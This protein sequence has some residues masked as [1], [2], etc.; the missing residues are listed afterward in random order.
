MKN[1]WILVMMFSSFLL[2]S[3][4]SEYDRIVKKELASDVIYEDLFLGMKLGQTQKEFF[5]ECWQLNSEGIV[6]Q[7]PDNENVRYSMPK[8]EIPN[9]SQNVDVLF[10]GIFDE[11]KVMRGMRMKFFYVGWAPWNDELKSDVLV[12]KLKGYFT[13]TYK[14]NDFIDLDLGVE[15]IKGYVKVDGNR[16]ILMY[17][18]DTK[19]VMVKIEDLRYKLNKNE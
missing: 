3:C 16:Q 19:E 2:I 8:G 5:A 4:K 12:E 17:P 11:S 13:K 9:E 15:A 18:V 7:G 14:G 1:S 10:Y 6:S